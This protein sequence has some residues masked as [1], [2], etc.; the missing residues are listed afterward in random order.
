[1]AEKEYPPAF[2]NEGGVSVPHVPTE[3]ER[4]RC[5]FSAKAGAECPVT[6]KMKKKEFEA[7]TRPA[8]CTTCIY[9]PHNN[10]KK[11]FV[12]ANK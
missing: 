1:M 3:S 2:E 5:A 6:E 9:H 10:L 8:D 4:L 12:R 7:P 11:A